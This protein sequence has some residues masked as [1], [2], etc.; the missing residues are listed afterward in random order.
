MTHPALLSRNYD[1]TTAWLKHAQILEEVRREEEPVNYSSN[2]RR[3]LRQITN[4]RI[5]RSRFGR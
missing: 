4:R 2:A 5:D 3:Y 1:A